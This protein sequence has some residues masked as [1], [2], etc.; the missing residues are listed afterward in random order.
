VQSTENRPMMG[1][2]SEVPGPRQPVTETA[3]PPHFQLMG[4]GRCGLGAPVGRASAPGEGSRPAGAV[5]LPSVHPP[6]SL[7]GCVASTAG[8]CP[9]FNR[10]QVVSEVPDIHRL[11][12]TAA[13]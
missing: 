6:P 9:A 10:A 1:L 5:P 3:S 4:F 7:S 12:L 13:G 2:S 8:C 11:S